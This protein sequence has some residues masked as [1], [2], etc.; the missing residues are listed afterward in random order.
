VRDL[1]VASAV[2]VDGPAAD[3]LDRLFSLAEVRDLLARVPPDWATQRDAL[4]YA[5][6]EAARAH[7]DQVAAS[8]NEETVID[9]FIADSAPDDLLD[10]AQAA[11]LL[12]LTPRRLRQL[13][14]QGMGK[15]IGGRWVFPRSLLEEFRE[16]R[17]G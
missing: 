7:R 3:F 12:G 1:F 10:T 9:D 15:R 14:E 6:R 13:G 16:A 8:G 17:H 4:R 11:R 5:V 2:V